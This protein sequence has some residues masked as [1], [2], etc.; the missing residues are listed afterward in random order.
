MRLARGSGLDGLA[1]MAP[2]SRSRRSDRRPAP[3]ASCARCWA[4]RRRACE[5]PWRRAASP[6]SRTRATSRRP[7]SAPAC[8]L[9]RGELEALG[10]SATC[11]P[12]ARGGCSGRARRWRP[13]PMAFAP[14]EAGM[15]HTDPLRLLPH[16]SRA[17]ALR[18]PR[19][20][21]CACIGRCIAAAG[22]S[23]E[24]VP[25]AKLEPIVAGLRAAGTRRPGSWT[26]ARARVIAAAAEAIQIEREPGRAAPAASSHWHAGARTRYGTAALPSSRPATRW[27]AAVEVRALGR[28]RPRRS[29]G[30]CGRAV[31]GTPSALRLAPSFWRRRRRWLPCRPLDF[32]ADAGLA[33]QLSR[34]L[35][36]LA[37]QLRR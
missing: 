34:G 10:L 22:G 30:A 7:S 4:C 19:R 37:L 13:S 36:G 12:S 29:C 33:E 26:L 9:P 14:P 2:W 18:R 25:L 23:G 3:C 5:P 11:W 15:V 8:A 35:R 20:S 24:P 1:G 6:G 27:R 16:R 31:K 32:W 21:P 17:A 28:G